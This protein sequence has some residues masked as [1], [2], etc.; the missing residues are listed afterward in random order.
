LDRKKLFYITRDTTGRNTGGREL[1]SSL[2]AELL[3]SICGQ[4]FTIFIIP[5]TQD[6]PF[7]KLLRG[8]RGLVNGLSNNVLLD[9]VSQVESNAINTVFLDGSNLGFLAMYLKRNLPHIEVITF[10]HNIET[11]FFWGLLRRSLNVKS[12][13]VFITNYIA[14][15]L[16]TRYSDRIICLN[17]RDSELL[18]RYFQRRASYICPLALRRPDTPNNVSQSVLPERPYALFVGGAFYANLQGIEWYSKYISPH[19]D[20]P[21]YVI[22]HGV[23]E[24]LNHCSLSSNIIILGSVEYLEPWYINSAF[25]IAPIFDG[26]GMKTKVAEALMYGKKI[27]GTPEAFI[28]YELALPSAGWCCSTPEQF[29][30][31]CITAA[32]EVSHPSNTNLV[33]IYYQHYSPDA[34]YRQFCRI[35][36]A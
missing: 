10:Y 12:L 29:L 14:E 28:G 35:L 11:R 25:V 8:L 7:A 9:V 17:T 15:R 21:L 24:S 33:S 5:Q 18:Y 1:L 19:L 23:K 22:G 36:R 3:K 6:S 16:A 4:H 13:L 26:S 31:A 2:H 32:H 27:V 34:V 30:N 20:I